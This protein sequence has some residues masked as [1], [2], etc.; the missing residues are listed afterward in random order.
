[1]RYGR[2]GACCG[3][4]KTTAGWRPATMNSVQRAIRQTC[5]QLQASMPGLDASYESWSP[6]F[7][8]R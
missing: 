7:A 2:S 6:S 3:G 1:M 4:P 8:Y 5:K